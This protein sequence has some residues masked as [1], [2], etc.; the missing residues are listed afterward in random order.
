LER[1]VKVVTDLLKK[2]PPPAPQ[3]PPFP[4]YQ[5]SAAWAGFMKQAFLFWPAA[6]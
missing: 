5:K 4:N 6:R 3:H 2:N 1:A